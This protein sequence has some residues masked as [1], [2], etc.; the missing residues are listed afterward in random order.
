[1]ALETEKQK[2]IHWEKIAQSWLHSRK[3]LIALVAFVIAGVG[4]FLRFLNGD[5][6]IGF[7]KYLLPTYMGANAAD[8]FSDALA[9]KISGGNDA[10]ADNK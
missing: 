9:K 3:A 7:M 8:G 5:Q 4:F 10:D 2:I 1:M 6:W